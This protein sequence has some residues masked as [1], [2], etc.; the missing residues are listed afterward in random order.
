MKKFRDETVGVTEETYQELQQLWLSDHLPF[1][2]SGLEAKL[3]ALS[4]KLPKAAGWI[5]NS[6]FEGCVAKR[7]LLQKLFKERAFRSINSRYT[8]TPKIRDMNS[9]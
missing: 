6:P 3:V 5:R 7:V 1:N 9:T 2:H 8:A 4:L